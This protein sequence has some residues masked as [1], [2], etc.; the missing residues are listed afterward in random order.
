MDV[1]W[2]QTAPR[3][4]VVDNQAATTSRPVPNLSL[5]ASN[6]IGTRTLP[7]ATITSASLIAT[8]SNVS[9]TAADIR[10]SNDNDDMVQAQ[11]KL[12]A[13]LMQ[14]IDNFEAEKNAMAEEVKALQAAVNRSN[15]ENAM[16]KSKLNQAS[17]ENRKLEEKL[18]KFKPVSKINLNLIQNK[19]NVDQ[20]NTTSN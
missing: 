5:I 16:L 20:P 8:Q 11:I 9:P 18:G 14:R 3:F 4:G 6:P 1:P 15:K 17:I 7:N 12:N 10:K 13:D 2:L 19:E